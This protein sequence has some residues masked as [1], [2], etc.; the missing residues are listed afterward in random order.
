M[1]MVILGGLHLMVNFGGLDCE[2][3]QSHASTMQVC[4]QQNKPPNLIRPKASTYEFA[5]PMSR[6]AMQQGHQ[7][8][9]E[10]FTRQAGRL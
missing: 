10:R 9:V 1:L 7:K 2:Q 3:R 8:R 6:T 4:I 5:A